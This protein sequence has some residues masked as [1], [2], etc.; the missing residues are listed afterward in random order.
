M[1]KKQFVKCADAVISVD[2]SE[3]LLRN[4]FGDHYLKDI[5]MF[6]IIFLSTTKRLKLILSSFQ[7]SV[8]PNL[9]AALFASNSPELIINFNTQ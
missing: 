5:A 7:Y 3:T 1:T 2:S 6:S 4:N 9:F 8:F